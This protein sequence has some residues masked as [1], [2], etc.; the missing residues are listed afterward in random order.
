[1]KVVFDTNV[2]ISNF[3]TKTG[4]SHYVFS[5]A[6]K[7]HLVI[8]SDYVLEEFEGKL[9]RKLKIPSPVVKRAVAFLRAR[10]VVLNV[11]E[12][13]KMEFSDK[14]DL[15]ILQLVEISKAHYFVTGDKKLLALKKMGPTLFLSPREMIQILESE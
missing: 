11:S 8:L 6:L 13:H 14:K 9:V 3:L 5:T 10:A 2:L 1:M 7:R 15:P 4:P 12:H